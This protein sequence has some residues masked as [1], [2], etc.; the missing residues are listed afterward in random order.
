MTF[1]AETTLALR[2][3]CSDYHDFPAP[4]SAFEQFI[5]LWESVEKS[6]ALASPIS[7]AACIAIRP[8]R[9]TSFNP[10][11][12]YFFDGCLCD[13]DVVCTAAA[14]SRITSLALIA[15]RQFAVTLHNRYG[16]ATFAAL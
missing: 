3:S 8:T 6:A 4:E 9:S 15:L 1:I 13:F 7:I 5:D 11:R 2:W 12:L 16:V 14:A 10:A